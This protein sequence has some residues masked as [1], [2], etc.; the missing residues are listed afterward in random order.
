MQHY[1]FFKIPYDQNENDKGL[2]IYEKGHLENGAIG[3]MKGNMSKKEYIGYKN[4]VPRMPKANN[5]EESNLYEVMRYAFICNDLALY[6]DVHPDNE[7]VLSEFNTYQV[8]YQ[9]AVNKFQN[10]YYALNKASEALE[11]IPWQWINNFNLGEA[12]K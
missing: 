5:E 7:E 2:T 11:E 1:N 12:T 10:N 8:L 4:Y 9:N 6:L 3:Y